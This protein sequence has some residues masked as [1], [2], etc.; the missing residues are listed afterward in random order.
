MSDVYYINCF[1]SGL[2]SPG[3]SRLI[4]ESLTKIGEDF[5]FQSL[6]ATLNP[7]H[8]TNA[9]SKYLSLLFHPIKPSMHRDSRVNF[10]KIIFL[11]KSSMDAKTET[12]SFG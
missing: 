5:G 11:P 2:H 12:R 3:G 7:T 8:G 1:I 10:Q 9:I 6:L 4:R